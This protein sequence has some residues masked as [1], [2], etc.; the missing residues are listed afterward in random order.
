MCFPCLLSWL[1][2]FSPLLKWVSLDPVRCLPKSVVSYFWGCRVNFSQVLSILFKRVCLGCVHSVLFVSSC[3]PWCQKKI[4]KL[5]CFVSVSSVLFVPPMHLLV[6]Q[7]VLWNAP[8]IFSILSILCASVALVKSADVVCQKTLHEW[9]KNVLFFAVF[10]SVSLT[11]TYCLKQP[12]SLQIPPGK[13]VRK[14]TE[15]GAAAFYCWVVGP[16]FFHGFNGVVRTLRRR[17][18]AQV[19]RQ[20]KQVYNLTLVGPKSV[21]FLRCY[22]HMTQKDYLPKSNGREKQPSRRTS[23]QKSKITAAKPST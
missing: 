21:G 10:Y 6:M 5:I 19:E 13:P 2:L 12:K 16:L 9:C 22:T 8:D 18:P 23:P 17:P 20:R 3:G 14:N 4:F 15:S 11:S 7:V 1:A